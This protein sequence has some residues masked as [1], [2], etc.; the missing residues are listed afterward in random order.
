MDHGPNRAA[1]VAAAKGRFAKEI[2]MTKHSN[3]VGAAARFALVGGVVSLAAC[4]TQVPTRPLGVEQR[5]ESASSRLDHEEIAAQ[6]DRQAVVDAAAAKR[7]QGYAQ[8]YRRNVS[9]R[10]GVQAH[11][12][13]AKHC[14]N[15]ARTYQQA[16]D[17]NNA[18]A[19]LHRQLAAE[20]K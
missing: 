6:Y 3:S 5:I 1:F 11:A 9:P 2:K 8:T 14:E 4:S 15:L 13:L 16:A 10:S 20:A 18:V 7:H 19:Q 17:E 12:D